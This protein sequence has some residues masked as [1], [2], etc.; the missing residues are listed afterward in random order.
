[1]EAKLGTVRIS[2]EVLSTIARLT[3]LGVPGVARMSDDLPASVDRLLKGRTGKAG[4]RMEI[5]DEAVAVNLY[6][7]VQQNVSVYQVCRDVQEQ[8]ARAI[9]D[10]VGMPVLAV[11]VYVENVA[12]SPSP[13]NAPG[14]TS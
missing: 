10:M 6:I 8:V 3:A 9:K 12:A 2:P 5:V 13:R 4:V 11:N 14:A 7:V 1:M